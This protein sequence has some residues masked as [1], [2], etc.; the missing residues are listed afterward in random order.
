M[1]GSVDEAA[2]LKLRP[3]PF[4]PYP[5]EKGLLRSTHL[6]QGCC[7]WPFDLVLAR[8]STGRRTTQAAAS[9]PGGEYPLAVPPYTE[10]RWRKAEAVGR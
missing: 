6:A 7:R 8:T 3:I 9:L 1:H 5:Y 2:P 10:W 4:C